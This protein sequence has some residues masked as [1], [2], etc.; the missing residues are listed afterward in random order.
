MYNNNV[1]IIYTS[2][3]CTSCRRIKN[4]L[5]INNIPFIEKNIFKTLLKNDELK[6]L[7]SITKNGID[8][9]INRN[10]NVIL[11]SHIDID[12]LNLDELCQF[13]A[14]NPCVINRPIVICDKNNEYDCIKS[15]AICN[16]DCSHYSTCGEFREV[17]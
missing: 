10:C 7:L 4:Y 8:D 17:L 6:V 15:M 2:P 12:S 9:V 11:D 5:K 13:L 1:L 14:Q 3:G 16:K